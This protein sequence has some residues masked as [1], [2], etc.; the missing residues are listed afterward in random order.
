MHR[1]DELNKARGGHQSLGSELKLVTRFTVRPWTSTLTQEIQSPTHVLSKTIIH[2]FSI[3]VGEF[4]CAVS[5]GISASGIASSA[6]HFAGHGDAHTDPHLALPRI[7]EFLDEPHREELV[8]FRPLIAEDVYTIMTG[9]KMALP[10]TTIRISRVLFPG[11]SPPIFPGATWP[12]Y[13]MI[14]SR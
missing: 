1:R 14:V 4:A 13:S 6:K 10:K 7:T 2:S 8:P 11:T 3:W 9:H 5:R 12:S